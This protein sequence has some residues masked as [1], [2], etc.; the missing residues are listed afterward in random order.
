LQHV[1]SAAQ[2]VDVAIP[3]ELLKE[4]VDQGKPPD[5]FVAQQYRNAKRKSDEVLRKQQ[6]MQVLAGSVRAQGAALLEGSPQG[7]EQRAESS[8]G[9][10]SSC[11]GP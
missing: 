6:A 7:M 8:G 1:V 3:G 9:G 5:E 10:G 4:Y 11:S 2:H